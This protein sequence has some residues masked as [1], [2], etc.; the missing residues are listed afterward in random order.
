M[1]E[2]LLLLV[3]IVS[4]VCSAAAF[5]YFLRRHKYWQSFALLGLAILLCIW[6][7]FPIYLG[8]TEVAFPVKIENVTFI[9]TI[10]DS[11]GSKA[12]LTKNQIFSPKSDNY[13]CHWDRNLAA[14][15]RIENFSTTFG[16][17]TDVRTVSSYQEVLTEFHM[18]LRKNEVYGRTLAFDVI[19]SFT[20]RVESLNYEVDYPTEKA[21][22]IIRFPKSRPLKRIQKHTIRYGAEEHKSKTLPTSSPRL[23]VWHIEKPEVGWKYHLQWEW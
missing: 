8:P 12:T 13:L 20:R 2:N 7:F 11:T 5:A 3:K 16:K 18:P 14:T 17:I 10:E 19:D 21:I 22:V 6:I 15:G 1:L 4:S 23:I 9:L